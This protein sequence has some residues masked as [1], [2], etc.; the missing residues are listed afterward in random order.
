[1]ESLRDFYGSEVG[2]YFIAGA[3]AVLRLQTWK[4][5]EALPGLAEIIAVTRA[6]FAI[7]SL[8]PEPGWPPIH[9]MEMPSIDVSATDIRERVRAGRSIDFLVPFEVASYI[10]DHGLY[11]GTPEVAA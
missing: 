4:K 2:L 7:G 8:R 5:I 11:V 3:D 1:M 10:R 9:V 6:G